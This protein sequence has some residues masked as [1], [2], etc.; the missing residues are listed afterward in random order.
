MD[1]NGQRMVGIFANIKDEH[2]REEPFPYACIPGA[3]DQD[4]YDELVEGYPDSSYLC[5]DIWAENNQ[6]KAM[7]CTRARKMGILSP[8]WEKFVEYHHS[9]AFWRDLVAVMGDHMRQCH[10]DLEDRL[11]KPLESLT[12]GPRFLDHEADVQLECQFGINT[13]VREPTR[14]RSVHVDSPMKIF[15]AL[16]YMRLDEDDSEGGDLNIYKFTGHPRFHDQVAVSDDHVEVV[17]HVPYRANI[18]ISMINS[19]HTLHGVSPR[20]PTQHIRRYVNFL[21][22][23][24]IPVFD[25]GPYQDTGTPWALMAHKP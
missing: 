19:V 9:T 3:L 24:R 12:A 10:P 22:E 17:D 21:A 23:L 6:H 16:L 5:D 25:L 13:P 20:Q 2:I 18:L 11:G 8:A 1:E 7:S 15:N 4:Y 14:V